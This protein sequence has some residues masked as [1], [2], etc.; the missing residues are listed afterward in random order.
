[1][2]QKQKL[3]HIF[4]PAGLLGGRTAIVQQEMFS[5]TGNLRYLNRK[6]E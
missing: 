6:L 5:R 3:G 4:I 2:L 1:M